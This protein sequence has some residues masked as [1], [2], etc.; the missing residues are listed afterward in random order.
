MYVF[1][2]TYNAQSVDYFSSKTFCFR[3]TYTWFESR[4][5]KPFLGVLFEL[6]SDSL[7]APVVKFPRKF[8]ILSALA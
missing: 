3:P 6:S 7:T 2:C 4:Y 8:S 1:T 5:L